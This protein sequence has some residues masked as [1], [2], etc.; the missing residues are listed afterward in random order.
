MS[1]ALF[2]GR[3]QPFHKGHMRAVLD[4]LKE[5]DKVIVC[6]GSAQESR[7]EQNPLSYDQRTEMI[8]Y[9]LGDAEVP[10][11]KY[12][13][14]ALTDVNNDLLWIGHVESHCPKF[15]VVYTGNSHVKKLFA[16]SGYKVKDVDIFRNV[17]SSMIRRKMA[18]GLVWKKFVPNAV[19]YYLDDIDAVGLIK[20]LTGKKRDK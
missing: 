18:H 2:V 14:I 11:R 15:D 5:C 7:T 6:V 13:I 1:T 16:R 12:K 8:K 19:A 3:F 4:I 20:G 9:A 17:S 10:L